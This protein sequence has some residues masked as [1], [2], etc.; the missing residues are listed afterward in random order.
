VYSGA[1]SGLLESE[2]FSL[3]YKSRFLGTLSDSQYYHPEIPQILLQ[4]IISS[5]QLYG[6]RV[7]FSPAIMRQHSVPVAA[8]LM[9]YQVE[10]PCQN[11]FFTKTLFILLNIPR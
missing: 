10:W 1:S 7:A 11:H 8:Q 9:A 3:L 6:L 5:Q 2:I 4:N